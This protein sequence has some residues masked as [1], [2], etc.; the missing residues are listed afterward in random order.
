MSD[1]TE[2]QDKERVA[3]HEEI[4]AVCRSHD[5]RMVFFSLLTHAAMVGER[6]IAAKLAK[7][8]QIAAFFE[9][10]SKDALTPEDKPVAVQYMD[11][12]E[13]LGRKH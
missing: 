1:S 5:S 9:T 8:E 10:A 7:P 13:K 2:F 6:L 3:I 12:G 4:M 11:G